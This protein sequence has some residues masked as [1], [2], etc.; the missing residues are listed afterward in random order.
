MVLEESLVFFNEEDADTFIRFLKKQ[1]CPA[2][3]S[4][5]GV[6]SKD[7]TV[8]GDLKDVIA[9]L[10][11]GE[12]LS[13]NGVGVQADT[14]IALVKTIL[15]ESTGGT[16]PPM[17][18]ALL[19]ARLELTLGVL[20]DLMDAHN[21]GD[22]ICSREDL[23]E[24]QKEL[25]GLTGSLSRVEPTARLL[26][27]M[28]LFSCLEFLEEYDLITPSPEGIILE[29]A[30]DP[31]CI[32]IERNVPDPYAFSDEL[33]Q[34]YEVSVDQEVQYTMQVRVRTGPELY[35][36]CNTGE[37]AIALLDLAVDPESLKLL[38]FNR[39]H[40]TYIIDEILG[41]LK[42]YEKMSLDKIIP[43]LE[44]FVLITDVIEED[45]MSGFVSEEFVREIIHNL[46]TAKI[47]R[48]TDDSLQLAKTS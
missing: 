14:A 15:A 45:T 25:T 13:G 11:K 22:V 23:V 41:L 40:K 10:K 37:F 8:S 3:K 47:I 29:E 20:T 48:G 31:D 26:E 36:T 46:R 12:E 1:G 24:I 4:K 39:T 7:T 2:V 19:L 28:P 38:M 5:E 44:S 18:N 42:E 17:T 9:F 6:V 43:Y 32:L 27:R 35:F 21:E 30:F 34:E 16:P 33:S